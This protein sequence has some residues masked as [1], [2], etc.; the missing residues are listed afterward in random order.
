MCCN[1]GSFSFIPSIRSKSS[2]TLSSSLSF[3]PRPGPTFSFRPLKSTFIDNVSLSPDRPVSFYDLLG[4]S[5][6]GTQLEI[7]QAYKQQA[8]KY[9]PDVSPPDKVQEYTER[10]IRVQEA[11]ETLSDPR[12]RALYDSD[13]AEGLHPAFSARGRNKLDEQ[14]EE[15]SHWNSR[16]QSQLSELKRRSIYKNSSDNISWGER[17]RRQRNSSSS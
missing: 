13:M 7:K 12:R 11:Y 3:Q 5:E 2:D 14:M 9:H 8:R 16:W 4:I 1:Y 6:T 17:M 15:K 10:F